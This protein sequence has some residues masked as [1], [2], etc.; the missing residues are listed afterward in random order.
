MTFNF[1]R[2]EQQIHLPYCEGEIPSADRSGT[3][4]APPPAAGSSAAA[5]DSVSS[6]P[7][8]PKGLED[9][10]RIAQR[11]AKFLLVYVH[12]QHHA[13]C[14]LF[15]DGVLSDASFAAFL[16]EQV[17]VHAVDVDSREGRYVYHHLD[18]KCFPYVALFVKRTRLLD[19]QGDGL[20]LDLVKSE[21][22][23][24]IETGGAELAE[25]IAFV[26][27]REA[28]EWERL[29]HQR[30]FDEAMRRDAERE[31]ALAAERA[32]EAELQREREEQ[33]AAAVRLAAEEEAA[34]QQA[35][36]DAAERVRRLELDKQAA[37]AKLP[38]SVATAAADVA[39]T[40]IRL[41]SLQ[42]SRCDYAFETSQ[43]LSVLYVLARSRPEYDGRPFE[44]VVGARPPLEVVRDAPDRSIASVPA[45]LGR[46]V[47]TMREPRGASS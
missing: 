33:A 4:A 9:A 23:W 5:S 7:L 3:A 11:S 38:P 46:V 6:D 12:S 31:A 32:R 40:A 47:V 13:G 44:L 28:R 36:R 2:H 25:E 35:E 27:E 15:L 19:L 29:Q 22:A 34:R 30:E 17:L 24:G 26:R 16:S 42:G 18:V 39:T 10:L 21:L 20:T 37:L 1:L 41:T 14:R 8:M 45:L 43:P